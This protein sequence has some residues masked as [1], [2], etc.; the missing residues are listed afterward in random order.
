MHPSPFLREVLAGGGSTAIVSAFLNP[1]DV[2]KTRRQLFAYRELSALEVARKLSQEGRGGIVALWAPGL[3]ATIARELVYSGCTK[4]VYPI[5]RDFI[6]GDREPT[7][8]QRVAAASATGFTGSIGANAFD[9]VK[10]RQFDAPARYEGGLLS[11]MRAIARE[12]GLVTGLLLRGCSASAPRGA[13]IAVGEVTTYDHTKSILRQHYEDGCALAGRRR[14]AV[15]CSPA[16]S[17]PHP[18]LSRLLLLSSRL[19]HGQ[20]RLTRDR[21]ADH[22]RR[23]DDRRRAI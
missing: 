7:L 4:G 2:I 9:V 12:E 22:G 16:R 23:G 17:L 5:A 10:I 19:A 13:A 8:V 6:A 3:S 18:F 11:A 14:A 1:V 21:L 20:L 15:S